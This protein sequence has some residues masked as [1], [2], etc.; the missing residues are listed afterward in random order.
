MAI[1]VMK[2]LHE[3]NK[4]IGYDVKIIGF[5]DIILSKMIIPELSTIRQPI[6]A[7]SQL[8]VELLMK[9]INSEQVEIKTYHFEV[10]LV[11]RASSKPI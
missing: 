7:M 10:E 2:A 5:D 3:L 1:G 11:V 9:Q 8:A 4:K 6:S